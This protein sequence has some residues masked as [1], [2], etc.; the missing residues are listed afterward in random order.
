M[1]WISAYLSLEYQTSNCD[2][3]ALLSD[4]AEDSQGVLRNRVILPMSKPKDCDAMHF[5][6]LPRIFQTTKVSNHAKTSPLYLSFP[7][8]NKQYKGNS[9]RQDTGADGFVGLGQHIS[10]DGSRLRHGNRSHICGYS[11]LTLA[12]GD[13]PKPCFS[14]LRPASRLLLGKSKGNV[15]VRF[16]D[17]SDERID[18]P[19]SQTASNSFNSGNRLSIS[20]LKVQGIQEQDAS[21]KENQV[22]KHS[23]GLKLGEDWHSTAIFASNYLASPP[24]QEFRRSRS[25]HHS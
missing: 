21:H 5:R 10:K 3:S 9:K 6:S 4:T 23:P 16:W 24:L 17:D 2:T 19:R 13:L 11:K 20:Q 15:T 22:Q 1:I 7:K 14:E 18:P 25:N 12:S 8:V